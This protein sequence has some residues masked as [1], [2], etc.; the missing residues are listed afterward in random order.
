MHENYKYRQAT[1]H[2]EVVS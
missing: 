2:N 1:W